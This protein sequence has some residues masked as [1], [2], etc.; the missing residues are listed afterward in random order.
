MRAA[1]IWLV[2]ATAASAQTQPPISVE[3]FGHTILFAPPPWTATETAA[4]GS[5]VSRAETPTAFTLEFRPRGQAAEAWI[6]L[7][8]LSVDAPFQGTALDHRNALARDYTAACA[9][10]ALQPV[11]DQPG[12]QVFLL[13]CTAYRGDPQVGE[14]ALMHYRAAGG[15][16]ARNGYRKR[17][18]AYS[19]DDP[20]TLPLTRA[21][22]A[23]L[24]SR[25]ATLDIN[26]LP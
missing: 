14:I 24:L 22:I 18:A 19:L 17:G 8:A 26:P 1:L 2:L 15:L 11:V 10:S 12:Q 9:D 4:T 23:A 20:G 13:F 5:E 6:E 3:T 7:Y 16:L 25:L 21:E